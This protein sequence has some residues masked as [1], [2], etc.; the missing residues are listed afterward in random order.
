M[1]DRLRGEM[2]KL[3]ADEW[4]TLDGVIQTPGYA[5]EDTSG[6]FHQGGWHLQSFRLVEGQVT[7]TGAFL[8]T[9]R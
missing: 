9:E 2:R 7:T 5:D 8:A 1:I 4:M 3:I 6:G